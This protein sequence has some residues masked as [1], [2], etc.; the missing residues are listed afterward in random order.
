MYANPYIAISAANAGVIKLGKSGNLIVLT[1]N[2]GNDTLVKKSLEV[3]ISVGQ[4]V[5]ITSVSKVKGSNYAGWEVKRLGAG[6]GNTIQLINTRKFEQFDL[7]QIILNVKSVKSGGPSIVTANVTFV[8]GPNPD[9]GGGQAAS[10]GDMSPDDNN[11]T[12]SFTVK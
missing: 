6:A 3:T 5:R 10:Q 11:S 2:A 8:L 4:N 9:L 1:G 12:S 7:S